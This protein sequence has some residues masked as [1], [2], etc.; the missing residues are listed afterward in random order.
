M[1]GARLEE[2]A[3]RRRRLL[4][5]SARLR[6]EIAA[7]RRYLMRSLDSVDRYYSIARGLAKPVA[8]AGAGLLLLKIL[9]R[10]GRAAGGGFAVRALV[11]VSMARRL[12]PLVGLARAYMKSRSRPAPEQEPS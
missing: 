7:D 2:L 10:G 3:L 6:G 12:L 1:M 9:R 4:L 11:W 5:R 8:L